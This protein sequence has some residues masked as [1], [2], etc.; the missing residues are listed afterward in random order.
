MN[1]LFAS[2]SV[3]EHLA[4]GAVAGALLWWAIPNQDAH[5]GLALA[6]GGLAIVALRGCPMCW[7][8]GLVE[9]LRGR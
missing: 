8:I 5:A 7:A 4:R 1:G 2:G 9:T 6:A 3:A